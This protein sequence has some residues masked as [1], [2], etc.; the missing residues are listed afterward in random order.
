VFRVDA[1][2]LGPDCEFDTC[3]EGQIADK[4]AD[5]DFVTVLAFPAS[6]F[7]SCAPEIPDRQTVTANAA[8]TDLIDLN[9]LASCVFVF[10]KT[11]GPHS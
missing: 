11:I 8:I 7:V 2:S 5:S 6:G 4:G 1:R 9:M 3:D 10:L